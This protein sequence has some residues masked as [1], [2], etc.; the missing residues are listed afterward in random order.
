MYD[1]ATLTTF[2]V[3]SF[4]KQ[5]G[6]MIID[7]LTTSRRIATLINLQTIKGTGYTSITI[8]WIIPGI[9]GD[10]RHSF[11]LTYATRGNL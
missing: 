4:D 8:G 5:M 9:N 6:S 7:T 3:D 2:M 1:F 11:C 10:H